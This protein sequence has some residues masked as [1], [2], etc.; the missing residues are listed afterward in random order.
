MRA[1]DLTLDY[2]YW[3]YCEF[4]YSEEDGQATSLRKKLTVCVA[5]IMAAILPEDMLQEFPQ[6]FTQVGHVCMLSH[7]FVAK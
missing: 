4:H 2:D 1:Y 5:D 3:T 6:G 7:L